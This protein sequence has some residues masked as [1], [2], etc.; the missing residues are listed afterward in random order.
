MD[1]KTLRQNLLE[2]QPMFFDLAY[3]IVKQEV[4]GIQPAPNI[5]SNIDLSYERDEV[6]KDISEHLQ[7][8]LNNSPC[9]KEDYIYFNDE[10][11]LLESCL[12]HESS[13]KNE[14]INPVFIV[15]SFTN[16]GFG[17]VIKWWTNSK[18]S[19]SSLSFDYRLEK[20]YSFCF[21]PDKSKSGFVDESI[22][23]FRKKYE[24]SYITVNVV[25]LKNKY[26]KIMKSY[27]EELKTNRSKTTSF[28]GR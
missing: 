11:E 1:F 5:N 2:E 28:R 16:T 25:F 12:L 23:S 18:V 27:I 14:D 24:E 17:K 13:T 22:T 9:K 15:C 26:I 6:S 8:I 4:A 3:G 10:V 21:D 20:M 7:Y 19:H